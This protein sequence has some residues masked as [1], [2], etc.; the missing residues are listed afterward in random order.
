MGRLRLCLLAV[1]IQKGWGGSYRIDGSAQACRAPP[2]AIRRRSP[3]ACRRRRPPAT[4]RS[5]AV[6]K[7]APGDADAQRCKV[8]LLIEAGSHEEA[9][10]LAGSMPFEKVGG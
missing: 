6:L 7:L 1:D 9:L 3:A 5:R 4:T 8:V 2:T 10:K